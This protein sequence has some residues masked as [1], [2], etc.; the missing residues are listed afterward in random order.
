MDVKGAYQPK[1]PGG[2]HLGPYAKTPKPRLGGLPYPGA[3]TMFTPADPD[4]LG[5]HAYDGR[6]ARPE[7][8]KG[9][10][11]TC[12][13]GFID[14]AHVRKTL[15]LCK[16]AAVR[17]EIALQNDWSAF[18]LKGLEPSV[19]EVHLEYPPD[20]K[21]LPPEE[22]RQLV[23]ELSIR[24]GQ[25]TG[26]VMM[27]W[28]ETLTWFGYKASGLFS[29]RQSAFT[30]DDAGT[31]AL[32]VSIAGR[33][34]RDESRDWDAAVTAALGEQLHQLEPVK[35]E[36]MMQVIEQL[37]GVWWEG[38]QPLKRQFETGLEGRPIEAWIV[39]DLPFCNN[40][41][42]WRYELPTLNDVSGRD[43]SH[44]ARIEVYPNV[45]QSDD[46]L[47]KLPTKG[48]TVDVDRDFPVLLKYMRQWHLDHEGPAVLSPY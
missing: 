18:R 10:L 33:A 38:F 23:K 14:L 25:R 17:Y 8:E 3:F 48:S 21:T 47:S 27:T 15:D 45:W 43:F 29:E 12:R 16:F 41:Q 5:D 20:W 24:L 4:N 46:I 36:Q 9:I 42:P 31:H 32:G 1:P 11:Y 26:M 28:H 44:L 40:P 34:L 37:R 6:H 30:Y 2:I 35:P 13:A 39:R 19:Y 22:K 7:Q